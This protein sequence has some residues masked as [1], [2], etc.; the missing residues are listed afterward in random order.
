MRYTD[1]NTDLLRDWT[2]VSVPDQTVLPMGRTADSPEP[3]HY[4]LEMAWC[5]NYNNSDGGWSRFFNNFYFEDPKDAIV[6][7]MMKEKFK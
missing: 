5:Y 2:C 4:P 7:S 6:F 3:V 1:L